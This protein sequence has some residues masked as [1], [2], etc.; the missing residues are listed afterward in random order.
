MVILISALETFCFWHRNEQMQ[1]LKAYHG[2]LPSNEKRIKIT[3][4][5]YNMNEPQR[6]YVEQKKTHAKKKK[7][8]ILSGSINRKGKKSKN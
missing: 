6:H 4:T 1:I 8:Y 5:C 3:D 7:K 2:T